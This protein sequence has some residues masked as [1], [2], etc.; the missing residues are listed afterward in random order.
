MEGGEGDRGHSYTQYGIWAEKGWR[1]ALYGM[2][3]LE[4]ELSG[5]GV[6]EG[7]VFHGI[8]AGWV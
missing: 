2:W 3:G 7:D 4:L 6:I 8:Y 5:I 1:M